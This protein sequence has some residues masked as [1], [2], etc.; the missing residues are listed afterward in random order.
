MIDITRTIHY[1]DICDNLDTR[2]GERIKQ[3]KTEKPTG[4]DNTLAEFWLA[5]TSIPALWHHLTSKVVLNKENDEKA[6]QSVYGLI[7]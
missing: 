3:I 4:T 2:D 7:S 5:R 1:K 6:A